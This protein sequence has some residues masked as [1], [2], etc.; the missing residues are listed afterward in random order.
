[1]GLFHERDWGEVIRK[2]SERLIAG[3]YCNFEIMAE[4]NPSWSGGGTPISST[5]GTGGAMEEHG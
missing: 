4:I 5:N 1:M 2:D 3:L